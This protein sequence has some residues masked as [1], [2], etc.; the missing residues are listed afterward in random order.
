M[1]R[2]I[3]LGGMSALVC[4]CLAGVQRSVALEQSLERS[5]DA[6]NSFNA[7]DKA[8]DASSINVSSAAI[9][10][11]VPQPTVQ[12]FPLFYRATSGVA[13][14]TVVRGPVNDDLEQGLAEGRRLYGAGRL[15]A[16]RAVWRRT[17]KGYARV[18]DRQGQAL[19]LSY[20][21]LANQAL[22]QW[23]LASAT[24]DE[25]IALLKTV[26][27]QADGIVWA[28]VLN[29]QGSLLL[30]LGQGQAAYDSWER[31]Q[32]FY[33]AAGDGVGAL[34]SRI[35][36]ARALQRLGFYRRS[37]QQLLAIAAELKPMAVS[38]LKA[39]GL[40]SLGLALQVLGDAEGST[41]A[42]RESLAIARQVGARSEIH[43]V[44]LALGRSLLTANQPELALI[45]FKGVEQTTVY[46]T[47]RQRAQLKR[48]ATHVQLEQWST[49]A[50]LSA[51]LQAQF[52]DQFERG[53]LA[54]RGGFELLVRL[55]KLTL[56][57]AERSPDETIDKT[58]TSLLKT[59]NQLL[60]QGIRSAEAVGDERA[61]ALLLNKQ[62]EVYG[63]FGQY[64]EATV[65]A[66]RS[67][68]IAHRLQA[69][70]LVTQ[71]AWNLGR[72]QARQGDRET[73]ISSYSRAIQAL[74]SLRGDLVA[75]DPDLQ[76]SFRESVEPIYREFVTLL[77]PP[78]GQEKLQRPN[79]KNLQRARAAIEALQVAELDNF[80][81]EACVDANTVQIDNI[82]EKATAL[83]PI[84]LSDRLAVI[85]SAPGQP[86][87]YYATATKAGEI[88]TTLRSFINHLSPAYD[89]GKRLR[90]SQKIYNWL[91]APAQVDGAL[92]GAETLVFVLDGL[93][94]NIPIAALHNGEQYL[95][96]QY[97]V[98][99]SPGLQLVDTRGGTSSRRLVVGGVSEARQ[100]FQPLPGVKREVTAIAQQFST[101]VL[102][103]K[104]FTR[105]ALVQQIQ[106][107]PA[108]IVH[109]ATHGQFSSQADKTFLLTW[110]SQVDVQELGEVLRRRRLSGI[111]A[112]DLLVLSACETAAGDDRAVLGL[113]GIAVESGARS[114][115]ATLWQVRDDS[116]E[117]FMG[118]FYRQ[119]QRP[120]VGKA[121]AL[122]QTQ[123][124]LLKTEAYSEP[125][126]W[127]PFILV[128]NWL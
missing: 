42:L 4:I 34:G 83:Y 46:P 126:F 66:Q 39:N 44:Q 94:R 48:L 20:V 60:A 61:Q 49:V 105:R 32:K 7:F 59:A 86:L 12:S 103:D 95:I 106:G 69:M 54:D 108:G 51:D 73:A 101:S 40:K 65:L 41:R 33:E 85:V 100:G 24:M 6:F 111:R 21:S 127:S 88:E 17:A 87:R 92:E 104:N 29:T 31:A 117:L 90:L 35:N 37:Q 80:F 115:I 81:R 122:R 75:I 50:A 128:G 99:L 18:G 27:K 107:N 2:S 58:T 91:I 116:T 5:I 26:G 120:G 102:L 55:V 79:P 71:S 125:F 15:A 68:A 78:L 124:A 47:V 23:S 53:E 1:Y 74:K 25:A 119:L 97:S 43:D 57:A 123:L 64:R 72:L 36:Q 118:E 67:L 62:G 70:D 38:P 8:S 114:T 11:S 9:T 63:Y 109:L 14:V 112:I 56:R 98:A 89:T 84:L 30:G 77:L 16:A 82:D 22:N 96:E 52:Q 10:H 76:F 45:Q 19:S 28:Q 93:L 13:S 110:D 121:E 3:V 113:A